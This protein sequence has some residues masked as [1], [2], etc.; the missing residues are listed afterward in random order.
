MKE[1]PILFSTSMVQ[2]LLA[3]RKTQTR[4]EI[5]ESY[6]GC[7]TNGG[8]HPCPNDPFVFYPGEK[9]E[10]PFNEG[11]MMEVEGDKVYADFFC[12]TMNKRAYCRFGKPGDLLWVRECFQRLDYPDGTDTQFRY[13]ADQP[14]GYKTTWKPSIHMPKA[15]ARIWLEVTDITVQRVQDISGDGILCEGVRY[16]I[17]QSDIPGMVHPVF[18]MGNQNNALSFMPKGWEDLPEELKS[19]ALLYSHWAEL[20]CE[21]NSVESW[22][23]NP[24]V[25]VVSFKIL[26][27]T[28]RPHK[29]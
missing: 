4:R 28:G 16:G 15:A 24:W 13:K 19:E 7:L 9:F 23:Q 18:K 12:S 5:K 11:E 3:G 25:W 29:L 27:K 20:W 17:N 1:I 14:E 2:A 10:H 21:I 22:Q 6:N 8:P 26:S